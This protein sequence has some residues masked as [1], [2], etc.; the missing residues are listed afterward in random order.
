MGKY[1]NSEQAKVEEEMKADDAAQAQITQLQQQLESAGK[2]I[3]AV[4]DTLG[5]YAIRVAELEIQNSEKDLE[6]RG[7]KMA[8]GTVE[9]AANGNGG[10]DNR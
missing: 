8:L 6:I 4:S 3:Q 7:L 1:L 9:K 5:R 10:D 2:R